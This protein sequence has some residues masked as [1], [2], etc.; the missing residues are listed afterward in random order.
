MQ[1]QRT[2]LWIVFSMSLLL[3]WDSWQRHNGKPSLLMGMGTQTE[4][5]AGAKSAPPAAPGA[6]A[7]TDASVPRP[8]TVP[9]APGAGADRRH[10]VP[11]SPA[12]ALIKLRSDTLAL[13]VDPVGGQIRRAELLKHKAGSE[14][15]GRNAGHVV[16]L[17]DDRAGSMSPSRAWWATG[18]RRL[19][20]HQ[21]LHRDRGAAGARSGRP[22]GVQA[23]GRALWLVRT[24]RW[25]AAV[26]WST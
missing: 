18:Q 9:A 26:M 16:L 22:V 24:T 17:H 3:V 13:E 11:A 21:H 8:G 1:L 7:K 12:A 15:I 23:H 25:P 6:A 20:T 10:A 19:P 2:I 5:K 14:T 4:T